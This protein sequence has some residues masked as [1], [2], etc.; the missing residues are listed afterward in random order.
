LFIVGF[1]G[2]SVLDS[3]GLVPVGWHPALARVSG[4]LVAVALAGIG[5]SLR[6]AELRRAGARPLLLGGLL[7]VLVAVSSLG[8]QAAVGWR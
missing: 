2:A 8:L 5:L 6:P 7:W 1:V 3:L 4:Y